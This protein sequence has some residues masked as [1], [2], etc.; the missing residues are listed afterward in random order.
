L[1]Q[2]ESLSP[3]PHPFAARDQGGKVKAPEQTLIAV[4]RGVHVPLALPREMKALVGKYGP[5]AVRV[6]ELF[7]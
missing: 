7:S 3:V 6:A 2:N 4:R 1:T 5:A